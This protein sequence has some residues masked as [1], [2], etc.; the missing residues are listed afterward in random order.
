MS[1]G[2]HRALINDNTTS[3]Q[4]KALYP[5]IGRNLK[6][7]YKNNL[8]RKREENNCLCVGQ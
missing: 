7:L 1:E 4:I 5:N 6:T 8:S 3:L 2:N